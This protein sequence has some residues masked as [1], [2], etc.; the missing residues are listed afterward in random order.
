MTDR[1]ASSTRRGFVAVCV[2]GVLAGL[3]GCAETSE[4]PQY[5][6]G[7]VNRTNR[8]TRTNGTERTAQ[9]TS[10]AEA[11]AITEPNTNA[12]PLESLVVESHEYVVKQ[13]YKGPV[14][15]G[16]VVNTG[17]ER[18]Q[19]VEIRVRVYNADGDQLGRYLART[20]DLAGGNAWQFEVILLAPASSIADYDIVVLGVPN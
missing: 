12:V 15:Q 9:E 13:G 20:G 8:T 11:A 10:A 5:Q 2:G 18:V 1:A 17:S 4:G 7:A 19:V 14:V 16:T 6:E 3:A